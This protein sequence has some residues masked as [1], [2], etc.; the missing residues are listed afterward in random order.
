MK[1]KFDINLK[2]K[3]GRNYAH[4]TD[5]YD[6]II[7]EIKKE[8]TS[9][10]NIS[11]TINRLIQNQ[12]DCY[13]VKN[14]DLNENDV[15]CLIRFESENIEYV[16]V[17][18]SNKEKITQ[19]YPYAE[20]KITDLTKI[21]EKTIM[22]EDN[23]DYSNIEKIVAMNKALLKSIFS[24]HNGKW[25]FTRLTLDTDFDKISYNKYHLTLI[26]NM[27]VKLTKTEIQLNDKPVGYIYFSL[28]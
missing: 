10:S 9:L 19:E 27:G 12:T 28:V 7:A 14:V 16:A 22:L 4:G 20:S 26:K 13:I 1:K 24:E 6:L 5:L 15:D 18:K 3:G 21:K 11:V 2:Y 23:I 17:I 8:F 25:I